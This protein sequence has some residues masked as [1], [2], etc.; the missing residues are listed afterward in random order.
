M[1]T[2]T[3][4]SSA[5]VQLDR[6][7]ELRHEAASSSIFAVLKNHPQSKRVTI[8]GEEFYI[9]E[10]DLVLDEDQLAIYAL[11][12][13]TLKKARLL[14]IS[15][16]IEQA[17]G[18][19]LV[20]IVQNGKLVRWKEDLILTYCV[21][22][23]M[24]FSQER[25]QMVRD[26]MKR[27]TEDWQKTCGVKFEYRAE[28]DDSPGTGNPGVLFTVRGIDAGAQFIAA[29]FF[30]ND[31]ANRRRVLIDPS[32]FDPFL[33]FDRAGVLRH[34]LGHVLGFRHEHICSGALAACPDEPLFGTTALT[35]YDPHSVMH[36]FC[37]GVGSR[38]LAM[39][40]LD[41]IGSQKLYGPPFDTFFFVG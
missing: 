23:G 7:P 32:Y 17:Q 1:S 21:L 35:E 10:G 36:Y 8:D 37:G 15:S 14:G 2:Q 5:A 34:E 27:A 31:P 9:A 39:T 13:E 6:Q 20:G 26:H 4:R 19:A 33:T 28:L 11:Q 22:K 12:Q 40:E 41:R 25:Y 16:S 29:A 24:L 18:E 30:P 38:E 3:V